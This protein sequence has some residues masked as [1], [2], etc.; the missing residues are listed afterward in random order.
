MM[1]PIIFTGA[2]LLA[3]ALTGEAMAG[4]SNCSKNPVAVAANL[5]T[6][7]KN[8]TVCEVATNATT[9]PDKTWGAQEEHRWSAGSGGALWDYKRGP[10]ST[11]DPPTAIG[12]W[13]VT[14][15]GITAAVV[16]YTYSGGGGGSGAGYKVYN[17]LD[18][19]YDFCSGAVRVATVTIAAGAGVTGV[20][21]TGFAHG[22]P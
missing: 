12:T 9:A 2:L 21:C 5:L 17:N 18:G 3:S 10:A 1:K 8:N 22:A 20:G 7:L 6:L 4:A 15:G 16:N 11:I 19:S 14:G 13:S